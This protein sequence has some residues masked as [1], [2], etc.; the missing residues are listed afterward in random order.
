MSVGRAWQGVRR[1]GP[2]ANPR[3]CLAAAYSCR[4]AWLG[5]PGQPSP[6]G[7][8]RY[9]AALPL[10]PRLYACGV[11]RCDAQEVA[12]RVTQCHLT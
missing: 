5:N 2:E 11:M 1:C 8:T 6:P 9:F 12:G 3:A 10:P 7:S 4:L